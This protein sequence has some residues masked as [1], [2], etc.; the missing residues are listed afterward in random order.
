MRDSET[1]EQ[2]YAGNASTVTSYPIGFQF[3]DDTDLEVIVTDVD[4]VQSVLTP[5]A[6]YTVTRDSVTES[7][8]SS[9]RVLSRP[10]ARSKSTARIVCF[11]NM[12]M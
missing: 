6:D 8:A 5:A 1:Y 3:L 9:L 4:G 12:T 2:S 11:N 10:R 7:A